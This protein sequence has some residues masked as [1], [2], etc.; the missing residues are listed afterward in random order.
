MNF[1]SAYSQHL[2]LIQEKIWRRPFSIEGIFV[3]LQF[4]LIWAREGIKRKEQEQFTGNTWEK[5]V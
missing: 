5:A 2:L 1:G 4:L 3:A